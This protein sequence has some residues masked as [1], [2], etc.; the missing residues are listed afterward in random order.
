MQHDIYFRFLKVNLL[1][2][3]N[4]I[5]LRCIESQR[6]ISMHSRPR[7]WMWVVSFMPDPSGKTLLVPTG[8][9]SRYPLE[10]VWTWFCTEKSLSVPGIKPKP[11]SPQSLYWMSYAGCFSIF[12][13]HK[14][15]FMLLFSN[16]LTLLLY[17]CT[18]LHRY[19]Q[20]MIRMKCFRL[21]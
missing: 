16:K 6:Q 8:H 18:V 10:P 3:L 20:G 15:D 5:L 4:T 21:F 12:L 19:K 17:K 2:C 7:Y 13:I 1:L 11:S 14:D 9:E